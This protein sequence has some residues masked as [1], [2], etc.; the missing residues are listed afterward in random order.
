MT[1][2]AAAEGLLGSNFEPVQP[3]HTFGG[4]FRF[5]SSSWLPNSGI[6]TGPFIA[7]L[8]C[9]EIMAFAAPCVKIPGT[10]WFPVAVCPPPFGVVDGFVLDVE[11]EVVMVGVELIA[12]FAV[13]DIAIS[14]LSRR[15]GCGTAARNFL[16]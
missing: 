4:I 14:F 10:S 1:K 15:D 11:V 13:V 8:A 9:A 16:V 7:K 2:A 5:S 6:L 12:E 3:A